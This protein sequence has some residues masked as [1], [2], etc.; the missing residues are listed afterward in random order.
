MCTEIFP[1][2]IVNLYLKILN[3]SFFW[4]RHHICSN[5]LLILFRY[6][7]RKKLRYYLGIFP[8]WRTPPPIPPFGNPLFEEKKIIV[9]F[10]F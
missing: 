9:C 6:A 8:K 3:G 7:L 5:L 10:A 4:N 1:S 2:P